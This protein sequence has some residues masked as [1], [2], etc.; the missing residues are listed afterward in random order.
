MIGKEAQSEFQALAF[1]AL[2]GIGRIYLFDTNPAVKAKCV[3]NLRRCGFDVTACP[4]AVAALEGA[5]IA[6]R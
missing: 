4:T 1:P 6:Q 3:A 5:Q 2:L